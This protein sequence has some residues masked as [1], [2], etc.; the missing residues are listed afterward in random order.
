MFN[1]IKLIDKAF[2]KV[3]EI[4]KK[5]NYEYEPIYFTKKKGWKRN[6]FFKELKKD[7]VKD[8]TEFGFCPYIPKACDDQQKN[9]SISKF[10]K[11]DNFSK[12]DYLKSL[13]KKLNQDEIGKSKEKSNINLNNSKVKKINKYSLTSMR[14]KRNKSSIDV[15]LAKN[16][17][18]MLASIA[19]G[20]K[21]NLKKKLN[22]LNKNKNKKIFRRN[23]SMV[24]FGFKKDKTTFKSENEL[25]DAESFIYE[26]EKIFFIHNQNY[27]RENNSFEDDTTYLPKNNTIFNKYPKKKILKVWK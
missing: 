8:V 23:S 11:N 6:L 15:E 1:N 12:L 17:K 18:K 27:N 19:N 3:Y 7:F 14:I 5:V 2:D 9:K 21:Y 4:E 16:K 26:P 10:A 13:Y 24:N 25:V 22:I 20:Q